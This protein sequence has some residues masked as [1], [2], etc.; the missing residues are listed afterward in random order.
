MIMSFVQIT[1]ADFQE[2]R[3]LAETSFGRIAYVERGE[4]AAAIFFHG[5]SLNGFQWRD[6]LGLLSAHRRCIAL[7]FMGMGYTETSANQDLSPQAQVDMVVAFLDVLGVD[8]VDLVA[9][10][11]G[12]TI[13]QLFAVQHPQRVRT[14]LLT[15]CDVHENS[16]PKDFLPFIENAKA[17]RAADEW[18]APQLADKS[19]ARSDN[20]CGL[21]YTNA[22]NFTDEVI[23]YYYS[24]LLA[25]ALRKA[26]FNEYAAA[27]L[28]NP[29]LAIEAALKR[30]S[31]PTRMVWGTNDFLFNISWAEWLDRTL[32]GS[33]GIRF[34]EGAKLFFPEEMPELIAEEAKALWLG[35]A[36]GA[37]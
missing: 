28:P 37:R 34:V 16:P 27:F 14:L 9:N 20:G 31:I 33:R 30:C 4:G 24:P 23:E 36:A 2:S 22:A 7:D 35:A 6:A 17:E 21:F 26:Q 18:L 29:L 10:D 1:A 19:L 5:F 8:T 13:A 11:S 3:R 15:N 32:P 12:G 25:T